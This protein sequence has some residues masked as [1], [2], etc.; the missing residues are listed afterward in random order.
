[1]TKYKNDDHRIMSD[2][3]TQYAMRSGRVSHLIKSKR[4]VSEEF[5]ALYINYENCGCKEKR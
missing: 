2:D 5:L 4:S 1:M 3:N